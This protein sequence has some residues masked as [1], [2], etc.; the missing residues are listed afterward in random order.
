MKTLGKMK[1]EELA[2]NAQQAFF[3]VGGTWEMVEGQPCRNQGQDHYL[4]QMRAYNR[5]M[6][7]LGLEPVCAAFQFAE[8][9]AAYAAA[10]GG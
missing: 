1:L 9:D 2:E 5:V 7:N 10:Y 6:Y 8:E 3:E 4:G